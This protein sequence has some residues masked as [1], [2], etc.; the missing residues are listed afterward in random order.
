MKHLEDQLQTQVFEY[1]AIRGI[2]A[3]HPKASG[4]KSIHSAVRDKK[5]GVKAGVPD[6]VIID[7][8]KHFY[9]ELK[10]GKGKLSP[11]QIEFR[12]YCYE[13]SIPWE[14]CRS[15]DEVIETLKGWGVI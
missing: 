9:I 8:G 13:W 12:D 4:K 3:Y 15:L 6:I 10:A 7:K 5:L 11:A 14:L 2:F 1:L